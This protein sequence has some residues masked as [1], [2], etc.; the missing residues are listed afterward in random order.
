MVR[1]SK[2]LITGAKLSD[3]R[4]WR[5]LLWRAWSPR[6]GGLVT[7]IGLNPSTADEDDDD[8]TIRRC[9]GFA[10]AWGHVGIIMV[11]L[12][13][14]RATDPGA[15]K[16]T[17]TPIGPKNDKAIIGAAERSDLVVCAWGAQGGHRRRDEE[18]CALLG[19][20]QLH[21]LGLTKG[22]QPKHPLYLKSSTKPQRW[23]GR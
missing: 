10:K 2:Y 22:G 14:Y 12:F 6:N 21:H 18:V 1:K 3:C 17:R 5:Y 16:S 23:R 11:N 9:V 7:F 8:P 15:M 13:A 19:E 4:T 20:Y